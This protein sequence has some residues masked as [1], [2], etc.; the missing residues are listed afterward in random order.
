M[1]LTRRI[2]SEKE[3]DPQHAELMIKKH[4]NGALADIELRFIAERTL[5][6]NP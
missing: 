3:A 6:T 4:R 1:F 5:F 2:L